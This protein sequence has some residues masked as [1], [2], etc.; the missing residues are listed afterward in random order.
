MIDK[1]LKTMDL[2]TLFNGIEEVPKQVL[3][4]LRAG[5]SVRELADE[6]IEPHI[7]K[8]EENAGQEMDPGYIGYLIEYV[9]LN[10]KNGQKPVQ[11]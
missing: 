5:R 3:N 4:G 9:L 8:I 6:F 7:Q 11:S 10:S 2:L 1:T